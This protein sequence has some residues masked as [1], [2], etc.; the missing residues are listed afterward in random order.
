MAW[1]D[2]KANFNALFEQEIFVFMDAIAAAMDE[3]QPH[4][5]GVTEPRTLAPSRPSAIR[6]LRRM[7][8]EG[9]LPRLVHEV[10]Q[11][12]PQELAKYWRKLQSWHRVTL[13][14]YQRQRLS[15]PIRPWSG[16][17]C[18]DIR[19]IP[20]EEA[21]SSPQRPEEA[22]PPAPTPPAP[23]QPKKAPQRPLKAPKSHASTKP[24]PRRKVV[25]RD[26]ELTDAQAI[27]AYEAHQN[28]AAAA[29]ALG[30]PRTTLVSRLD[31][32]GV[33][34]RDGR[35]LPPDSDPSNEEI[36]EAFQ[37]LGRTGAA[38]ELGLHRSTLSDRLKRLGYEPK[39]RVEPE[40]VPTDAEVLS[41]VE[42]HGTKTEAARA[43]GIPRTTLSSRLK[44]IEG[45][46]EE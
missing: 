1:D 2:S 16:Q 34:T 35:R 24:K 29:R 23:K 37:R 36:I 39:R 10:D 45:K 21:P 12:D 32:L 14:S 15:P 19:L 6:H 4:I 41:A 33:R 18:A 40:T 22:P 3:D 44:R 8:L 17:P 26:G 11:C 5:P 27:A 28:A 42:Q 13:A 31:R 38:R 7:V 9:K 43:L 20:T 30:I 25:P 46:A